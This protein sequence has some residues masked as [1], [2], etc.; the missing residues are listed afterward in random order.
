MSGRTSRPSPLRLAVARGGDGPG[1]WSSL[2][3]TIDGDDGRDARVA[4]EVIYERAERYGPQALLGRGGM[5]EVWLCRDTR[6]GR[7]VAMKV[8]RRRDDGQV[9]EA[10]RFLH[11]GRLQARLEHPAIVPVYD[12]GIA[13]DRAPFFT[14]KR[15]RGRTLQEVLRALARNDGTAREEYGR[16]RLL[17]A[18]GQVCL[19]IDYAHENGVVHRDLKPANVMLGRH[20]EVYV[21]DWGLAK[22]DASQEVPET[23]KRPRTRAGLV[24]GTPAY[25][26]PEQELCAAVDARSDVYSL[27]AILWVIL[28]LE[29]RGDA[30]TRGPTL[31]DE[32]TTPPPPPTGIDP[33]PPE[34]IAVCDR[35]MALQPAH[36]YPSA[37]ALW[38]AVERYLDGDRDLQLRRAQAFS[39][40]RAAERA[41]DRALRAP[42]TEAFCERRRALRELGQAL[43]LDPGHR[44]ARR[45]LVRLLAEPPGEV[46]AEVDAELD[47]NQAAADRTPG[48]YGSLALLCCL[49][50]TPLLCLMG[51]RDLSLLPIWLGALAGAVG[52]RVA[53]VFWPRLGLRAGVLLLSTIA[54][55]LVSQMFGPL[56]LLPGMVAANTVSYSLLPHR[57]L[58]IASLILGVACFVMPLCL[59]AAGVLAP[60]YSFDGGGM[61]I[62]SHVSGMPAGPTIALLLLGSI[63]IVLVPFSFVGRTAIALRDAKK[64]LAMHAWD[65]RQLVPD[66]GDPSDDATRT[67]WEG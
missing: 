54:F 58:R 33:A 50:V 37:R 30:P 17:A 41:A 10:A 63:G 1:S 60:S 46:P 20:G 3:P 65:L 67:I 24:V 38:T 57:G 29:R 7:E 43:A 34:L 13:P 14:M 44:G 64:R 42:G 21:L 23:G 28:T 12:V 66:E 62:R 4:E 40:A 16:R 15:V 8:A 35:A 55:S 51:A 22:V 25:M 11:E 5:G 49:L 53:S 19:A 56:V 6:I 61:T 45:T 52:L 26:A 2:A 36:R 59:E 31:G 9:I 39:H 18:F 47:A 27:G 48:L 32:R